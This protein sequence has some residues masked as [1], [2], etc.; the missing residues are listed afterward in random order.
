MGACCVITQRSNSLQ[1]VK[2]SF[3][4]QLSE[5]C[6]NHST[7]VGLDIFPAACSLNV[8][9]KF[10]SYF[11]VRRSVIQNC[12]RPSLHSRITQSLVLLK[13]QIFSSLAIQ[14]TSNQN[15]ARLRNA[16]EKFGGCRPQ[17][18]VRNKN[19]SKTA[20]FIF[21]FVYKAAK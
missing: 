12:Q 15:G 21:I 1:I 6:R 14:F 16:R 9:F 7:A 19:I 11:L 3:D 13:R 18:A 5:Q 2:Y 8:Y 20:K 17:Q 4:S 10:I